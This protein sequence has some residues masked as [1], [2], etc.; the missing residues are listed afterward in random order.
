MAHQAGFDILRMSYS[1]PVPDVRTLSPA[2]WAEAKPMPGIDF[3]MEV[4]RGLLAELQPYFKDFYGLLDENDIN[5][6]ALDN[7]MYGPI[8]AELLFGMIRHSRPRRVVEVGSGSSTLITARALELNR[9]EGDASELIS[10]DPAPRLPIPDIPW[11]RHIRG[12]VQDVRVVLDDLGAG[13]IL[14]ID[15]SHVVR[16]GSDV[17]FLVLERLPRAS[18]GL[19][20]HFHDIFLPWEYPRV[21]VENGKYW[22]EQYLLQAFLSGNPSYEV[23]LAAHA[24]WRTSSDH[25]VEAR[26]GW[27]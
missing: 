9:R 19:L 2:H 4:Q 6:F 3:R 22:T 27:P 11:H 20:V 10:I 5:G 24:L 14:F 16:L 1:S 12:K 25:F 23:T 13:D 26:I 17:N 15:S 21:S 18:P 7:P 8:D